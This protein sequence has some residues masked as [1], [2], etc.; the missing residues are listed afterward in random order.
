MTENTTENK[1]AE[2]KTFA[3]RTGGFNRG[4]D[5]GQRPGGK[6]DG[7]GRP[8]GKGGNFRDRPKPEFEQK[9]IDVRRV[10]RVMS[11]GRRFSYSV[12]TVVGDRK[13]NVGFGIGKSI[14]TAMAM[15]KAYRQAVKKMITLK[16][17][18]DGS[19][20]YELKSKFG[21]AKIT[22]MPNKGRGVV[23]GSAAR[24][25]L[26]LAGVKNV[27]SKYHSSTK[28]K[29]NNG[30]VAMEALKQISTPF[31]RKAREERKDG[32]QGGRRDGRRFVAKKFVRRPFVKR[33]D[34]AAPV[35]AT[36][37]IVTTE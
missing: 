23:A 14:D 18:K 22:M 4:G 28:N 17:T 3:P 34:A 8:G 31:V 7:K 37:T 24:T 6:G 11:G 13:G 5:R 1:V 2:V 27:T 33:E 12:V 10:T 19:I 25:V 36:P 20:P 29:L 21:S 35:E 32:E 30:K 16:L 26:A 9:M 15:D